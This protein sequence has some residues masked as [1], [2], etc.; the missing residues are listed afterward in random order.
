MLYTLY[1]KQTCIQRQRVNK[2]SEEKNTQ[3]TSVGNKKYK[4]DQT[5]SHNSNTK[6]LSIGT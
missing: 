4:S 2:K 3:K 5:K 6:Q 1:I